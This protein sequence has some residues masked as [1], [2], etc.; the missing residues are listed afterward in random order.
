[1]QGL[2]CGEL[3]SVTRSDELLAVCGGRI[4]A[5]VGKNNMSDM[6][7][8]RGSKHRKNGLYPVRRREI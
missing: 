3:H 8:W 7:G 2:P 5:R 6:L 1:L 4:S